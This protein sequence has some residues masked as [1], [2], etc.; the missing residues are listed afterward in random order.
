MRVPTTCSNSLRGIETISPA[1]GRPA[2]KLVT[3]WNFATFFRT[4][5]AALIDKAPAAAPLPLRWRL[6][7]TRRE[8]TLGATL[9]G[10]AG[11]LGLV[12]GLRSRVAP[13]FEEPRL[14]DGDARLVSFETREVRLGPWLLLDAA[15]GPQL[16]EP[17]ELAEP[18]DSAEPLGRDEEAGDGS[19]LAV[20]LDFSAEATR[21]DDF[22]EEGDRGD[23]G[24]CGMCGRAGRPS[25]AGGRCVCA[26]DRVGVWSKCRSSEW[27]TSGVG[28]VRLNLPES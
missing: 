20:E 4:L 23:R 1:G 6:R 2:I 7:V 15:L 18:E 28:R 24:G 3:G 14:P 9:L 21:G 22:A 12:F 25:R 19:S 11:T 5:D 8:E 16:L 26:P 13:R 27:P 10:G 17:L